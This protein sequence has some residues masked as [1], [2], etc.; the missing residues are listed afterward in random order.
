MTQGARDRTRVGTQTADGRRSIPADVCAVIVPLIGGEAL[1]RCVDAVRQQGIRVI[2]VAT[3]SSQ[4]DR[5]VTTISG[6]GQTVPQRR[7]TGARAADTGIV[8]FLEDTT[9]PDPDWGAAILAGFLNADVGGIGGPV[10]IAP[11]LPARSLA[12]GYCEYGRYQAGWFPELEAG[13]GNAQGMILVSALPGNNFAFRRDDLC[14]VLDS[15]DEGFIDGEVFNGLAQRGRLLAYQPRMAARFLHA[16]PEGARLTARFHHGRLFGGRR[17]ARSHALTR[18]GFALA[19]LALPLV[20]A[21]RTVRVLPP[22]PARKPRVLGWILVLH[23]AWAVG[24]AVGYLAGARSRSP[25]HW[26]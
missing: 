26:R 18:L 14:T 15:V 3:D 2:V 10:E 21:W 7:Q 24:E 25:R 9:I 17:L 23:S 8:A 6:A 11:D 19:A 4:I 1:S 22:G 20:L 13:S 16:Y 12:L 5:D